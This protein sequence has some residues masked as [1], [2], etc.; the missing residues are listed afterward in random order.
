MGRTHVRILAEH[1]FYVKSQ[2]AAQT[3]GDPLGAGIAAPRPDVQSALHAL[4]PQ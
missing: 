2:G 1:T 4:R 3:V